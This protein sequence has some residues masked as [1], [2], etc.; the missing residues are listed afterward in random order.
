MDEYINKLNENI[1]NLIDNIQ[2]PIIL[3]LGVQNGRSTKKFLE[4]CNNNDGK[5]YSV[6]ID[7]CADVVPKDPK[8]KFIQSRDDN[9]KLIKAEI[10]SKIDILYIDTLHEAKHVEN[11][12]FNYYDLIN[13]NGYIFIDD[14]SHLPYLKN[15]ERENFYCEINNKETFE[16]LLEIYLKNK[17]SFNLNFSFKSSG[18]AII[19]KINDSSLNK[20]LKIRTREFSLKNFVRKIC[21][22]L[23]T[24]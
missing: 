8:W 11:I 6:D 24:N 22:N 18:L 9:F 12:F 10:P 2:K 15:Q 19:Q 21:S 3:E 5:L 13:E 16:C 23:K 1:I 20:R 4:I 7:N 17:D 14:I